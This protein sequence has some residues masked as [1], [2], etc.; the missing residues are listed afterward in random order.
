MITYDTP[1]MMELKKVF[2]P[3]S[4]EYSTYKLVENAPKEAVSALNKYLE[5][6][7]KQYDD[8]VA[9]WFE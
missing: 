3:Y 4:K 8:E 6:D 7:K 2:K 5:L 1:E 9:S